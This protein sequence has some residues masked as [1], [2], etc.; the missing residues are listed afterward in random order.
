MAKKTSTRKTAKRSYKPVTRP[1]LMVCLLPEVAERARDCVDFLSGPPERL[2]FT[3]TA[4]L[5]RAL[6]REVGRLAKKYHDGK[7]F[8]PRG[9]ELRRGSRP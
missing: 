7:P 4:L 2:S 9:Q 6:D 5:E 8:P 3:L 1:Q